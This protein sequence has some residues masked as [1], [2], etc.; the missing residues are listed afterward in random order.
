MGKRQPEGYG[1]FG[2]AGRGTILAHRY[3]WELAHGE[4][5]EDV[6]VCHTC[7]NPPCCNERHHFL[8]TVVDNNADRHR[9]S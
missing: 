5:P 1:R 2:V 4:I 6:M 9:Q 8:G 7:D 3:A